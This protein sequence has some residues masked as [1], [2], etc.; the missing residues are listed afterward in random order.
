M[1]RKRFIALCIGTGMMLVFF[2]NCGTDYNLQ[3]ATDPASKISNTTSTEVSCESTNT[4]TAPS[5]NFVLKT[6]NFGTQ[7]TTKPVDMVWVFDNSGSMREEANHVRTNFRNFMSGLNKE[8][9]TR[10]AMIS[11]TTNNAY[12]T[13]INLSGS[14]EINYLE[15]NYFVD[16]YNPLLVA[17][18]ATC[19]PNDPDDL[20]TVFSED[21]RYAR[22]IGSLNRFFRAVSSKVFVFVTDDNSQKATNTTIQIDRFPNPFSAVSVKLLIEN[23]HFITGDTFIRRM[24]TFFGQSTPYRVY[25]FI[26]TNNE[27]C[28]ARDS[29]EYKGVIGR[30]SGEYFDICDTNWSPHF[31]KLGEAIT[32]YAKTDYVLDAIETTMLKRIVSVSLNNQILTLGNDYTVNGKQISLNA[33]LVK[34]QNVYSVDV[35]YEEY[36]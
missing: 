36:F 6:Q 35:A 17:A 31:S 3:T 29:L 2:Q 11:S 10:V 33:E 21:S 27:K 26:A 13:Q 28:A 5:P 7:T 12:G 9:D 32:T 18:A 8:T 24:D 22:V 20:C 34:M 1:S 25:G 19:Q 16:S 14:G 23:L 4:C 15:V 30:K